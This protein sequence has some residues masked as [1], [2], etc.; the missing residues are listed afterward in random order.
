MIYSDL[1]PTILALPG[2][3]LT[4]RG[5]S[6]LRKKRKPQPQI[7]ETFS[8]YTVLRFTQ[9]VPFR[10]LDI[11]LTG[12]EGADMMF[13]VN[14]MVANRNRRSEMSCIPLHFNIREIC[15]PSPVPGC[16]CILQAGKALHIMGSMLFNLSTLHDALSADRY[17]VL[18][19]CEFVK[20]PGFPVFMISDDHTRPRGLD[21][22]D[23]IFKSKH[24]IRATRL[25]QFLST[26]ENC[27]LVCQK[28]HLVELAHVSRAD[29]E[30][31]LFN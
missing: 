28:N 21:N 13:A 4:W 1:I 24:D 15:S 16:Y 23:V 2:A 30:S 11:I 17:Y 10:Q 31:V 6:E 5:I 9:M 29:K 25:L 12:E 18:W 20:N 22:D 19:E 3:L 7:S 26:V 14:H 8:H 27:L